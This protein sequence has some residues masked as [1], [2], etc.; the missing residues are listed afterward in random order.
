MAKVSAADIAAKVRGLYKP[1]DAR[2]EIIGTGDS[3]KRPTKPEDFI[4]ADKS[5]PWTALT[6][7][8]GIPFDVVTQIAGAPDSGK[9]TVAGQFM[10]W[11][12]KQG[13]YVVLWDT[14]K[15]FDKI[16][17]EK[18]FGGSSSDLNIVATTII[19][20]GAGAM[21]RYVGAIMEADPKAKVL[22]V[23]DSVGGSVSRARAEREFDDDKNAQP[24]SE[25]VENSDYMRHV[26]AT[27]DKYEGR[28]AL[29][30]I[31]QMT[32]KIGPMPGKS[33][34]GGNKISFHS[35]MIIE[36]TRVQDLTKV[37]KGVRVKT[38]IVSRAK[39]AKNH[40]SLSENSVHEMRVRVT[41][42]GWEFLDGEVS[43]E[44]GNEDDAA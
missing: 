24:A 31:N 22:L 7:L 13:V 43:G 20:K 17:F 10:A 23:H 4:L 11:A 27:F 21:L 8:L 28:I 1:N 32:D 16:R 26:I 14:E 15:K 5:H 9:S 29:L 34:S 40:L 18:H 37:V 30:L 35:S 41:A 25:A 42:R 19:R 38:G 33:R 3:L 39:I 12:Q 2:R 6:G 36:M 44:S